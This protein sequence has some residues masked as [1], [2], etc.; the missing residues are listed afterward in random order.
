MLGGMILPAV[1]HLLML[2]AAQRMVPIDAEALRAAVGQL[3]AA[4]LADDRDHLVA[5]RRVGLALI[6][7]G[8]YD[9]AISALERAV[10]I[11]VRLGD[12]RA[13]VAARINLGDAHRYAGHRD[14]AAEQYTRAL[15]L[16]RTQVPDLVDFAQQHLGKHYI[17]A[18]EQ[19]LARA[20]L[21]EALRLRQAKGDAGLLAPTKAALTLLDT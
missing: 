1:E 12:T 11:A 7:L 3:R 21:T 9:D 17:E 20:C 2:D 8:E 19:D 5:S 6:A 4:D 13:Q 16:A 15:E 10:T 18:G 14:H